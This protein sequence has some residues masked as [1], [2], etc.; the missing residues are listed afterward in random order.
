MSKNP[1]NW[2]KYLIST[3]KSSY[4][5]NN[6]RNFNEIFKE[7]NL[8]FILFLEDT[9]LEK[10]QE[11]GI[12]LTLTSYFIVVFLMPL[13]DDWKMF[14]EKKY[15][16][17]MLLLWKF[18]QIKNLN[19]KNWSCIIHPQCLAF[20]LLNIIIYFPVPSA[21]TLIELVT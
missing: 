18:S 1:K 3:K 8:G 17:K 19:N 4:F 10:P 2:W 9:F 14:E 20:S 6:L 15:L 11:G 21:N 16:Q 5:L 13:T 7:K 12:K